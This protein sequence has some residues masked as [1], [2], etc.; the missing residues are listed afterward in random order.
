MRI[1][2]IIDSLKVGGA[3][4]LVATLVSYAP[5]EQ[6]ELTVV[7]LAKEESS[8]ILDQIQIC[9]VPVFSFPA[10]SLVD[11]LRFRRLCSFFAQRKV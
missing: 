10:G 8:A 7:S 5:K 6:L 4:K 9:G 3:Q 11:P 1:V 2:I